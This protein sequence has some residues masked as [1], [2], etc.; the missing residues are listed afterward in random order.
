MKRLIYLSFVLCTLIACKTE[1]VTYTI[2]NGTILNQSDKKLQI[3]K[4]SISVDITLDESGNFS[5]TLRLKD[6]QY[7][8]T[9]GRTSIPI[10]IKKGQH[11]TFNTDN[12]DFV[13]S[14]TFSGEG[15]KSCQYYQDVTKLISNTVKIDE[16]VYADKEQFSSTVGKL[17]SDFNSILERTVDF[18]SLTKAEQIKGLGIMEESL[19]RIYTDKQASSVAFNGQMFR[20]FEYDNISGNKTSLSDLKGQ[21]VYVDFWATWCGPCVKEFPAL[22]KLEEDYKS[23]DLTVLSISTD[24]NVEAWKKMVNDKHLGGIQ[25][26]FG[27]DLDIMKSF[28]IRSIPRFMILDKEGKIIHSDAPK[29]SSNALKL[30][31]DKLNL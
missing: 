8:L 22:K 3:S 6:G 31:L 5:D 9:Y 13:K 18:D 15:A 4:D 23:K 20:D 29:P 7:R 11:L 14:S 28:N 16:L 2:F 26:H 30:E 21:Y 1:P 17:K 24:R 12:N 27:D 19:K 25:V 10:Y